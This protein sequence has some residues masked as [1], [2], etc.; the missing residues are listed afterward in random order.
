M[1]E[2]KFYQALVN[3]LPDMVWAFDKDFVIRIGNAA[4]FDMRYELYKSNLKIGDSLF[5]DV[6]E[7]AKNKWMPV[8]ERVLE[9]ERIL[10]DDVRNIQGKES[11]VKLSLNPVYGESG[12]IIG[13]MGI[14]YDISNESQLE[15]QVN[16]MQKKMD[17]L[18]GLFQQ[19][20]QPRFAKFFAISQQL[21]LIGN[22]STDDQSAMVYLINEELGQLNKKLN[23][24]IKQM[25]GET[26]T[27][28]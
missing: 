26:N 17:D 12:D 27:L 7:S 24:F 9:G 25:N 1:N 5:K 13:C 20:L 3:S 10:M 23:D 28:F 18:Q 2:D 8:Y 16:Q 4:F 19:Q 22:Y 14:T 6:T 21:S 15:I 11:M